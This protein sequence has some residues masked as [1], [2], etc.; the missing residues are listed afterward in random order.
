MSATGF[1]IPPL[2]TNVE[3]QR[4]CEKCDSE[5][6]FIAGWW[7]ATGL[8]GCCIGCGDERIAPFTHTTTG[9]EQ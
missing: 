2:E 3:F 7:C 1:V 4:Y 6:I 5:Q 8:V 9:A